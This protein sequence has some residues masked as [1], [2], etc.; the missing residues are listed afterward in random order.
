MDNLVIGPVQQKWVLEIPF[1]QQ[2]VLFAALRAPDGIRK[3]HP[4]KVLLRWYRR[5]ILLSAFDQ[6][7][8][9][10]PFEPGGGSFTGPFERHH[11]IAAGLQPRYAVRNWDDQ[12]EE[13]FGRM[14]LV[15]LDHVDELPH[16][17]QLHFMH[18]AQIVGVHHREPSTRRWWKEFYYMIVEDAHL[19]PESDEDM[20]K[21]LSDSREEWL[22]REVRTAQ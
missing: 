12:K 1:M 15:Y 10:T 18:S 17:F 4:V 8:L 13:T 9:T 21:R 14:R 16:H 6:R 7:A 3:N 11:A 19:Y 2:S 5:C 22:R 20:N